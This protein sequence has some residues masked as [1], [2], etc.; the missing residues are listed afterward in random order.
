MQ[1]REG[2]IASAIPSSDMCREAREW[3]VSCVSGVCCISEECKCGLLAQARRCEGCTS[4]L[5]E[6]NLQERDVSK[7]EQ[8]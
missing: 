5:Y 8:G 1:S 4:E 2:R 3:V 7:R 6:Q